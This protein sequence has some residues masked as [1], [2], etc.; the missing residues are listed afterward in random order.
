MDKASAIIGLSGE[1]SSELRM[2]R[3]SPDLIVYDPLEYAW[4]NFTR[5]VRLSVRP[6]QKVLFAGMNPGPYGMLQ[7]GVPFGEIDSV[8]GYLGICGSV[9]KPREESPQKPVEGME[10]RHHEVSGRKFWAMASAI[11]P[12]DAFFASAA[13]VNYCPL[14]FIRGRRNVTPEELCR[15]D[16]EA[17]YSICDRY[18]RSI[19]EILDIPV[20]IG[21]GHFA[22]RKL[23]EAGMEDVGYF[24]HPSPRNP[25]SIRFWDS[26]EA[27]RRVRSILDEA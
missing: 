8:K 26:G 9:G 14:G 20:G 10:T 2:V 21:L 24:P 1:M 12:A 11:G 13:V 18:F 23:R 22:E 17:V 16:R 3:F 6:G 27:V 7:T 5:F 19:I 15:E 25:S 4:D